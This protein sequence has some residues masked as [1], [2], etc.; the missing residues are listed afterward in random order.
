MFSRPQNAGD[1][2][3]TLQALQ[4]RVQQLEGRGGVGGV[5][6][7]RK[8][9]SSGCVALDRLL[10]GGGFATGQLV[11]WLGEGWGSGVGTL[12]FWMASRAVGEGRALVVVDRQRKFYP[13]AVVYR[14]VVVVMK[15]G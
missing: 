12:A 15:R 8:V 11:E 9:V 2:S 10:P 3:T 6:Q 13:P 1:L 7:D 14:G 5:G 4:A